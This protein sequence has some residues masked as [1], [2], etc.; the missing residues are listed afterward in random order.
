[1]HSTAPPPLIISRREPP[2]VWV[3]GARAAIIHLLQ[4]SSR[5]SQPP[6]SARSVY[7]RSSAGISSNGQDPPLTS[8]LLRPLLTYSLPCGVR[9]FVLP[10][11][12]SPSTRLSPLRRSADLTS[13]IINTSIP[14]AAELH[15]SPLHHHYPKKS[16]TRAPRPCIEILVASNRCLRRH[17]IGSDVRGAPLPPFAAA[18]RPI[19]RSPIRR[20]W[21]CWATSWPCA[22]TAQRAD[23]AARQ[24]P[25]AGAARRRQ[26]RR[27]R[28]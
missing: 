10:L 8:L 3:S 15:T 21:Q 1:M 17:R 20:R 26:S 24:A 18:R 2:P 27:R 19:R 13:P 11:R 7:S 16:S 4:S 22:E 28:R 9:A 14:A 12:A 5:V 6:L 25:T 23:C